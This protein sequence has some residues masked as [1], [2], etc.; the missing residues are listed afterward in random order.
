MLDMCRE[1]GNILR[2]MFTYWQ[3]NSSDRARRQAIKQNKDFINNF[4]QN[5]SGERCRAPTLGASNIRGSYS[6][7]HSRKNPQLKSTEIS[8][9]G[10]PCRLLY[11]YPSH[12]RRCR[13][14][15]AIGSLGKARN[16]FAPSVMAWVC[17][18][19]AVAWF[20][21]VAL[22]DLSCDPCLQAL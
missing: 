6:M 3:L 1:V 8:H 9:E 17:C 5:S 10:V 16:L 7:I 12:T 14:L 21:D 2:A 4:S 18:F 19:T 11:L 22:T 20:I 15:R 13:R